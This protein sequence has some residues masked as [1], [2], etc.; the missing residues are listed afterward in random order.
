MGNIDVGGDVNMAAEKGG[1]GGAGDVSLER[2][3][4]RGVLLPV[5]ERDRKENNPPE[6][7]GTGVDEP[8]GEAGSFPV[9]LAYRSCEMR[10]L[11]CQS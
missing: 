4:D 10:P 6:P 1:N 2:A 3:G 7:D 5:D 8:E 11:W 9:T